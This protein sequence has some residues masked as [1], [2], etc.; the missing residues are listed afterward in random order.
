MNAIN[1]LLQWSPK[2][3]MFI[4]VLSHYWTIDYARQEKVY[5]AD[6]NETIFETNDNKYKVRYL[7]RLRQTS[8]NQATLRNLS[9]HTEPPEFDGGWV[10]LARKQHTVGLE[11][12]VNDVIGMAVSQRIQDLSQVMAA[13]NITRC[14][15]CKDEH[16]IRNMFIMWIYLINGL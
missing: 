15:I 11:V 10:L 5:Q 2:L 3:K 14:Q 13:R 6:W 9:G 7:S 1:F 12:S 16:D 8:R 4:R